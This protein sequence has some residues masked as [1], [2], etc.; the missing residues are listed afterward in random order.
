MAK[1]TAVYLQ[2]WKTAE[3]QNRM[4]YWY[5]QRPGWI[6]RASSE[7]KKARV[8]CKVYDSVYTTFFKRQTY[9]HQQINGDPVKERLNKKW[10]WLKK[11][12]HV[13]SCGDEICISTGP[14][15]RPDQCQYPG[16]FVLRFC[17]CYLWG[18]LDKGYMGS[19]CSSSYNCMWIYTSLKKFI[20]FYF[21]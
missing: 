12:Q 6:S 3:Q 21:F 9:R 8:S 18:K 7:M 2:S 19:R 13:E 4:D 5:T 20:L 10:M 16:C 11:R 15:S 1:Q 17:K 14:V